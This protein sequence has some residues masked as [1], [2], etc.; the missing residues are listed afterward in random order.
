MWL[1]SES[2]VAYAISFVSV[3]TCSSANTVLQTC[4]SKD[5]RDVFNQEARKQGLT[6]SSLMRHYIYRGLEE[7]WVKK[8]APQVVLNEPQVVITD[9]VAEARDRRAHSFAN[10][11]T[12]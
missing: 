12:A 7:D 9:E 10:R 4:V 1:S 5:F 2:L 11:L 3:R 6:A 8:D